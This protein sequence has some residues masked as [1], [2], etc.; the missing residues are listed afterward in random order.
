M[1]YK[2]TGVIKGEV[3]RYCDCSYCQGHGGPGKRDVA[4]EVEALTL[5]E[6]AKE[7]LYKAAGDGGFEDAAWDGEPEVVE[8]P[9]KIMLRLGAPTLFDLSN[10]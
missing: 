7:G 4:V 9:E 3:I 10:L 2:V 1:L 5:D 6:A 8:F